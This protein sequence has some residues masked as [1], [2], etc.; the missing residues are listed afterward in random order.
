MPLKIG[1]TGGIGSGKSTVAKIFELLEV[2]VYYA[3]A[4]SKRL[5]HTDKV[6][7]AALKHQFGEDIYA[8]DQLD[9]DKLASIVFADKT[10]LDLLNSL[11]HPPTIRD[12]EEWCARQQAPYVIKE[13]ALLFESGS[14]AGLDYVVGVF[15]PPHL[16][17]KRVMERDGSTRDDVLRRMNQQ[18][19]E[20]IKMKLC[21][22]VI[23]NNEQELVIPQVLALHQV[24]LRLA[25]HND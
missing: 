23:S 4:A 25:K 9:R 21:D 12:A 8:G 13:A 1:L 5:Y 16:R 22:F 15:A 18:I 7:I 17:I 6:L 10:K 20:N 3:D 24:L 19:D 2:P 11:V 14:A